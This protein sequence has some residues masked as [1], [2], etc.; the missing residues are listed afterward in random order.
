MKKVICLLLVICMALAAAACTKEQ[1]MQKD[2]IGQNTQTSQTVSQ[3]DADELVLVWCCRDLN[4][5]QGIKA[6]AI[7]NYLADE[8]NKN[9][10]VNGGNVRVEFID[11]G[12]D[13]QSYLDALLLATEV[14]GVDGIFG[15][16]WSQF[17]I[18][19]SDYIADTGIPTFNMCTNEELANC[20]DYYYLPRGTNLGMTYS[21][22][23]IGI[24]NGITKPA[25]IFFNSSSGYNQDAYIVD[26]FKKNG[27][28]IAA[29]IPFD[30]TNTND[31]TPHVLEAINSGADGVF[32]IGNADSQTQ[33]IINLLHEYK[34][35]GVISGVASLMT[36]K[37]A[38]LCGAD[39]V[40]G[41]IGYAEYDPSIDTEANNAFKQ[42]W[43]ETL[44]LDG[45][46]LTISWHDASFYDVY[47]LFCLGAKLGGA[48]DRKQINEGIR[49]ISDY[50]GAMCTYSW[51]D[52]T[53]LANECYDVA[54][55]G[56]TDIVC[57]D[58][59]AIEHQ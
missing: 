23:Q 18:A 31:F 19:A 25:I 55:E 48:N 52:D 54:F 15:T 4:S 27:F 50:E 22:A 17:G 59:I 9:G 20:N 32:V 13:Q 1:D 11:A 38:E 21:W 56:T 53:S 37:F 43:Y 40:D 14:E 26:H 28:E 58:V 41:M 8:T 57:K 51:H 30:S 45:E 12:T 34:F 42:L 6:Q 44:D 33:S 16:F 35:D 24:N 2:G 39:T 3:D 46:G 29:E 5:D 36:P 10:G 7:L 49:M 47:H